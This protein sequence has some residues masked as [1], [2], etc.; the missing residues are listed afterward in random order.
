M[1]ESP[2]PLVML[3]DAKCDPNVLGLAQRA[4]LLYAVGLQNND[5]V[6]AVDAVEDLLIARADVSATEPTYS[7]HQMDF[8]LA[9]NLSVFFAPGAARHQ[10]QSRDK[11]KH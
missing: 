4:P 7:R 2:S 10:A 11:Q 3:L 5:A 1:D 6:D 8:Q 9:R